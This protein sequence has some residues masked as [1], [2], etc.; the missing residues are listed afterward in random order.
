MQNTHRLKTKTSRRKLR[1]WSYTAVVTQPPTDKDGKPIVN[2]K[3]GLPEP[4]PTP[5]VRVQRGRK[6]KDLINGPT[7]DLRSITL[8]SAADANSTAIEIQRD[9]RAEIEKTNPGAKVIVF[10]VPHET[11]SDA[12]LNQMQG[13]KDHNDILSLAFEL[14]S[15]DALKHRHPIASHLTWSEEEKAQKLKEAKDDYYKQ[16][17]DT[18][19]PPK[20]SE[21]K[22]AELESEPVL[23]SGDVDPSG[24][25]G[26]SGESLAEQ[27]A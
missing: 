13:L 24:Q 21:E 9:M 16:A 17:I 3:T 19:R 5:V 18:L 11:V 14:A 7:F 6:T 25:A 20:S 12:M 4:A 22:L 10:P 23:G 1:R 8:G 26:E 27:P 2:E 15:E